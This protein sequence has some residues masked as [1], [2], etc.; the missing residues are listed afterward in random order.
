HIALNGGTYD[1]IIHL[2]FN[3]RCEA[4]DKWLS[5][6]PSYENIH[7]IKFEDLAGA[8][9]GGSDEKRDNCIDTIFTILDIP[10]EKKSTVQDNLFG[11]GRYTFRSGQIDSWQK[12]LPPA[13]IKDCENSIGDYLQ[14]W[15]YK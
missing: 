4:I 1:G 3:Q 14:K 5:C 15:D 2:P 13:I 9:G 8:Q 11:K 12:D 10:E 6:R 7:I